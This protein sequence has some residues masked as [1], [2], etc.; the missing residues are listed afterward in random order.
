[1]TY[2]RQ[3]SILFAAPIICSAFV[4]LPL[5]SSIKSNVDLALESH[6][7]N[8]N[9]EVE[10]NIKIATGGLAAFLLGLSTVANSA[11]AAPTDLNVNIGKYF[12]I[13]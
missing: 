13:S 3:V 6:E 12:Y 11:L 7:K 5:R 1:M 9:D 10:S 2:K 4:H 8:W